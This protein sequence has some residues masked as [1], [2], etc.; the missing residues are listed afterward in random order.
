[1]KTVLFLENFKQFFYLI[2]LITYVFLFLI[3]LWGLYAVSVKEIDPGVIANFWLRFNIAHPVIA[4][5]MLL[6]CIGCIF[7]IKE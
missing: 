2:F 3:S 5:I 7:R 4:I 6:M 1:M